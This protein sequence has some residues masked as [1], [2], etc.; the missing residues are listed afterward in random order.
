[1]KL[2]YSPGA[3]SQAAHIALYETGLPFETARVDLATKQVESGEDYLAVNAKGAVP[4]LALDDGQILTEGAAVLHY[5]ADQAPAA[6]LLP[7]LGT[8]AYY[9]ELEWLNWLASE[10]HKAF[11]PLFHP[12]GDPAARARGLADVEAKLAFADAALAGSG[13]WLTGETFTVA[14]A[15]LFVILGW[16]RPF[17]LDL[18]RW[19]ALAALRRAA[20]A[21]PAVKAALHA[22]GFAA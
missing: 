1:M 14:D 15:Y 20:L 18:A 13:L 17:H 8:L 21:R 5:I 4:A 19:P 16:T 6:R 2:Y 11:S 3:C 10:L 22:E 9:R 12:S 7:P